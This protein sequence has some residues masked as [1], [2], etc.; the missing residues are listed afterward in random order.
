VSAYR[1][2]RD[3]TGAVSM[4]EETEALVGRIEPAILD[5]L[6]ADVDRLVEI[7][8]RWYL[9]N[10][11]GQLGRAADAHLERFRVLAEILPNVAPEGWR[12]EREKGMWRLVDRGVPEETARRHAFL[13]VL[14]H[15][16][17]VIAAS[18]LTGQ[19]IETIARTFA[20][21]GDATFIDWLEGRLEH[22]PTSTRW[23]RWALQALEDDL[24]LV[25]RLIAE[26]VVSEH[27]GLGPDEAVA[28]FLAAR[29]DVVERLRRFMSAFALEEVSD[30]AAVTVAV[31][32]IRA[33][34]A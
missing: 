12:R 32:Q 17:S 14:A 20:L 25:R 30:L 23:H 2:A 31:R 5:G 11:Q 29:E 9:A 13:P 27:P 33:L 15:G 18:E 7:S 28:A 22:V 6:M 26:R 4:W 34:A 10:A 24:R 16:P 19:P 21:V 8:A 1:I 3:V